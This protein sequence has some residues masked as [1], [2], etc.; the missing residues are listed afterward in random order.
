MEKLKEISDAKLVLAY[1]S[2]NKKSITILVKRW[3]YKFCRQ[4]YW[5]TNDSEISKDIA[6]DSW[7][8][9]LQKLD[10]LKNPEKFAYWALRIVCRKSIDWT[11]KKSKTLE[12]LKEYHRALN[13][14]IEDHNSKNI[15]SRIIA[16]SI[17]L[18]PDNQQFVLRLFYTENY[19]LK[20]I[21]EILKLSQ[22]TIKSRLFYARE[23]LKTIIKNRNYE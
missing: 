10:D 22:G 4:A 7:N 6:Q 11:R 21:S 17:K 23:K 1:Q 5:Y 16:N 20:Q 12:K 15:E 14:P 19:T 18:L 13:I 9:I 8:V 2:G 3:H